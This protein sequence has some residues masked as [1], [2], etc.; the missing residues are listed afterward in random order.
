MRSKT[1]DGKS[2]YCTSADIPAEVWVTSVNRGDERLVLPK[3]GYSSMALARDG[4]YYLSSSK[5]S[6]QLD[7]YRFADN[8]TQTLASVDRP[9]HPFLLSSSDGRSVLNTQVDR[10]DTDLMLVDPYR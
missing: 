7:F 2:I 4:L 6:A 1:F 5:K 8:T 3:A 9:V 10:H